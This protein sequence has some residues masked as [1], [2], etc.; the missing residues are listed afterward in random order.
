MYTLL[1]H[2]R[3]YLKLF[4]NERLLELANELNC[5]EFGKI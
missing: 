3:K 1:L 4:W 5:T 2:L